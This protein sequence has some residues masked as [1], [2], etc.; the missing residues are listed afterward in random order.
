MPRIP[1][2][3]FSCCHIPGQ[4]RKTSHFVCQVPRSHE[5]AR[6]CR[7]QTY[8]PGSR[9]NDRRRRRRNQYPIRQRC[10][11]GREHIDRASYSSETSCTMPQ[12]TG[13][14]GANASDGERDRVWLGIF[15]HDPFRPEVQG[16]LRLIAQRVP[17]IRKRDLSDHAPLLTKVA[18]SRSALCRVRRLVARRASAIPRGRS[19]PGP[20]PRPAR[21]I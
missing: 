12:G 6:R 21:R 20:R 10:A 5:S 13:R 14:P 4:L 1:R 18:T 11:C 16:D 15:R 8:R 19:P 9:R 7:G 3:A 17:Q 2:Q